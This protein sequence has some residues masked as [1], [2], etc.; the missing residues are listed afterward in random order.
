MTAHGWQKLVQMSPGAFGSGMLDGLGVPLPLFFGWAVT[1]I[2]LV[3]GLALILGLVTRL[4]AI[5]NAAV[6][7][8]ALILVKTGVGLL[9]PMGG[10][11]PGAELELG[12]IA[13]LVTVAFLGPGRPFLDHVLGIEDTVPAVAPATRTAA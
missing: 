12:L 6:L 9:S 1:L 8:G 4:A 2:E 5:L 3:G 11:M 10:P 13:G 7:I